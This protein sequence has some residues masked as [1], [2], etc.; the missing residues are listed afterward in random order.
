MN[1]KSIFFH[2]YNPVFKNMYLIAVRDVKWLLIHHNKLIE[3][4][5]NLECT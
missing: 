2:S 5:N 4:L 1:P 3:W